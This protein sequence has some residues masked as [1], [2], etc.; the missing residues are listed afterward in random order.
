MCGPLGNPQWSCI[1]IGDVRSERFLIQ[2]S[3]NWIRIPRAP[4][5]RF[6]CPRLG[7]LSGVLLLQNHG[8]EVMHEISWCV[9]VPVPMGRAVKKIAESEDRSVSNAVRTLLRE[10]LAA[11]GAIEARERSRGREAQAA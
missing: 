4:V 5:G 3:Y 8:G 1:Q 2:N 7:G 10:A 11:R 6:F 9:R